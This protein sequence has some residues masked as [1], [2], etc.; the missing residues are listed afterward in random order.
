MLS[1]LLSKP[2]PVWLGRCSTSDFLKVGSRSHGGQ[3]KNPD[4]R[5]SFEGKYLP[6]CGAREGEKATCGKVPFAGE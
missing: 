5:I 2:G 4:H 6:G 3:T 1:Q